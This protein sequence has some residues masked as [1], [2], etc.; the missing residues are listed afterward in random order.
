MTS[1]HEEGEFQQKWDGGG[2]RP[3]SLLAG[4]P[5]QQMENFSEIKKI[6]VFFSE[7]HV[8]NCL[9]SHR[10]KK[11]CWYFR[12]KKKPFLFSILTFLPNPRMETDEDDFM[13]MA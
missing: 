13:K 4:R 8:C 9:L 10:V 1:H 7:L 6:G 3:G 5:A 12:R 2:H 11:K